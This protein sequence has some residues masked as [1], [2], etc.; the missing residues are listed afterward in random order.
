MENTRVVKYSV[1]R[2]RNIKIA[3]IA[4]RRIDSIRRVLLL[5]SLDNIMK[6][7]RDKKMLKSGP[8]DF[9]SNSAIIID[10]LDR[11]SKTYF[12]LSLQR[13]LLFS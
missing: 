8:A 13:R 1:L 10:K 6:I 9:V 11:L 12:K 7:N 5:M 2:L 3:I 4:K